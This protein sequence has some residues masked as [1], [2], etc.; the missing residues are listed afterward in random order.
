MRSLSRNRKAITWACTVGACPQ[1]LF[2]PAH[3]V[4][5]QRSLVLGQELGPL[6]PRP[7]TVGS[8]HQHPRAT[9]A[10]HL[11][12]EH[13]MQAGIDAVARR[14]NVGLQIK[15]LLPDWQVASQGSCLGAEGRLSRVIPPHSLVKVPQLQS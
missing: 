13:H 6:S 11:A 14:L 4:L 2:Q 9:H 3:Q 7:S 15:V 10:S 12:A 8:P 5:G 1:P